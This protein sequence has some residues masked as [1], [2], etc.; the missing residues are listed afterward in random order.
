MSGGGC[1]VN[2]ECASINAKVACVK[3]VNNAEC[4]WVEETSDCITKECDKAPAKFIN[5]CET[6]LAKC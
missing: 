6:F 1:R 2:G 4:Y 5:S 3:D